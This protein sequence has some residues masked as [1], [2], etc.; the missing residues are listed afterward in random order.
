VV[1]GFSLDS[2]ANS[3]NTVLEKSAQ[4]QASANAQAVPEGVDAMPPVDGQALSEGD[5]AKA[6][7]PKAA[8]REEQISAFLDSGMRK[9]EAV[10]FGGSINLIL[11]APL[12]LLFSY[13]RRPKNPMLDLLIP[14]A[15]IALILLVYLEGTHQLLGT[16][17]IPKI[18]LQEFKDSATIYMNQFMQ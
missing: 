7:A 2:T 13:T 15:G 16:L 18:N 4:E 5:A 10:G 11:L 8:L 6:E 3:I 1:L 17:P 9:A 14:V 12:V